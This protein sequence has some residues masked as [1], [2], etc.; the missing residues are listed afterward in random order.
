MGGLLPLHHGDVGEDVGED[1]DHTG[2][3]P[4]EFPPPICN[5]RSL[6]RGFCVSA[7][8]L[9]VKALGGL[10]IVIFRSRRSFGKKDR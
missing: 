3:A 1:G 8:I 2:S 10:Y 9:F 5:S 6:F 4:P 7:A